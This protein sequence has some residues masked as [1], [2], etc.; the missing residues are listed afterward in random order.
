[1]V[2][3]LNV[4]FVNNILSSEISVDDSTLKRILIRLQYVF[5]LLVITIYRNILNVHLP[6]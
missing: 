1:M 3:F 2:D 5:T 4:I 6:D